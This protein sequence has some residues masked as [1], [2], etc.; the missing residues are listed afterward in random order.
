MATLTA[1]HPAPGTR[2]RM[3]G[4]GLDPRA[5]VRPAAAYT[6]VV[7]ARHRER[8]T[9][10]RHGARPTAVQ[11]TTVYVRRRLLVAAL[12]LAVVVAVWG[13]AGGALAG[14]TGRADLPPVRATT[15]ARSGDTLWGFAALYHGDRPT[16][17]Y[18]ADLEALNGGSNLQIGQQVLLP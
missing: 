15:V 16:D 1:L 3:A 10:V 18:L 4:P 6:V 13:G 9:S 8:I 7:P 2:L 5:L 14:G 17:E 12:L 11:T